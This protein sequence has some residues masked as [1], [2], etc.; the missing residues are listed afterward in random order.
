MKLPCCF[1][2]RSNKR[3][4]PQSS[5]DRRHATTLFSDS[6]DGHG[7]RPGARHQ[8]SV[9]E[10]LEPIKAPALSMDEVRQATEN[11]G[12][13][14]LIGEGSFGRVYLGRLKDGSSVAI[15]R[16]D[17]GNPQE[18]DNEFL[19]QVSRVSRLENANVVKLVG[20]CLDGNL[21]VLAYEYATLGSLHDILHG[22]KSIQGSQPGPI[23]DLMQRLRIAVGAA[24][25]L[26]YLHEKAL[27]S[28]IHR[29]IRSSNILLFDDY[30][31]KI[32]DFN[33]SNQAPDMAARLQ[34][35][36]VLGTFGYY[37]PEYAMTGELTHKSDIYSFGVVLLELLTGR[38]PV[39]HKLPRGEQSLITWATPRLTEDKVRQIIDPRLKGD[40]SLKAV[41]KL[42]AVA[43]LCVQFEADF[44]PNMS[45]VTQFCVFSV[46]EATELYKHVVTGWGSGKAFW[47]HASMF[48]H[49]LVYRIRGAMVCVQE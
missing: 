31:A 37:A 9:A 4:L 38:M 27:H 32:A 44:R 49:I 40:Y 6:M 42:A 25:G 30:S 18:S 48:S 5:N 21:R 46:M 14:S 2:F 26:E 22:R 33:L 20:Y 24:K 15:K 1:W 11:F 35:T 36:R 3:Y 16:L 10:I 45:T 23:L 12:S 7:Y 8:S 47:L 39:D 34:S 43:A 28:F 17:V 29:D 13:N 41:A 19:A